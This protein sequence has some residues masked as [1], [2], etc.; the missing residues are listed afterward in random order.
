MEKLKAE[1]G[2]ASGRV[3]AARPNGIQ[4][5]RS[6]F[7]S[8]LLLKLLK[9]NNAHQLANSRLVI[10]DGDGDVRLESIRPCRD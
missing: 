6:Q 7:L 4:T 3:A 2:C 8:L 10:A 5:R 9:P 1:D